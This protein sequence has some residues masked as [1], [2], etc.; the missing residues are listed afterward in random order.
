M[1]IVVFYV[2]INSAFVGKKISYSLPLLKQL[3]FNNIIK[4]IY[5][6]GKTKHT[7]ALFYSTR[8]GDWLL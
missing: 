4:K 6:Y 7:N 1:Q 8:Y 2:S 5:K 3:S